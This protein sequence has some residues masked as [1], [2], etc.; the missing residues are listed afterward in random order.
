MAKRRRKKT[1]TKLF[2]PCFLSAA[3]FVGWYIWSNKIE[4]Q[5]NR[6]VA[7]LAHPHADIAGDAWMKLSHL[8]FTKWE[9]YYLL[10]EH[11]RDNSPISFLIEKTTVLTDDGEKEVFSA[12]RRPIY[13]RTDEIYC[14]TV[15]EAIF[16]IA[17]NDER[18]VEEYSDNWD[19]WWQANR[20]AYDQ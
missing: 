3:L 5:I 17:H 2:W 14:R 7:L 10:L 1:G 11:Q 19:W 20:S 12:T 16:A 13:Y 9:A 4:Q 18:L 6:N 8:F 15:R